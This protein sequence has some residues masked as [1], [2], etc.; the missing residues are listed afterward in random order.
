MC[1]TLHLHERG[2][3]VSP[4]V[5]CCFVP[6]FLLNFMQYIKDNMSFYNPEPSRSLNVRREGKAKYKQ[7]KHATNITQRIRPF[8]NVL[9]DVPVALTKTTLQEI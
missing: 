5:P 4:A 7:E 9:V 1:L 2:K 3:K 8:F 6:N